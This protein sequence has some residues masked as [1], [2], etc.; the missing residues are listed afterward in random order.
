MFSESNA[1]GASLVL[2]AS[3]IAPDGVSIFRED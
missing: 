1:R 3:S 2:A